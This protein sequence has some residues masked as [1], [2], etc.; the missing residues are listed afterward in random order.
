MRLNQLTLENGT[1]FEH[2]YLYICIMKRLLL[3]VPIAL[4]SFTVPQWKIKT[5]TSEIK[6]KIKNFGSW[7]DG[8][9][10]GL[11]GNIHF[12]PNDLQHSSIT[13]SVDV[14][15]IDTKNSARD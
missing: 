15:T 5:E 3:F 7:V 10:S 11:S 2:I 8:T 9:L 13:G 4:M 6:F 14:N 12:D 1:C